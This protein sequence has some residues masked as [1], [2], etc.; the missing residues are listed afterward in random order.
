[1]DGPTHVFAHLGMIP[2]CKRLGGNS[3]LH[4]GTLAFLSLDGDHPSPN[5]SL[6]IRS[7]PVHLV[8]RWL[9]LY[10]LLLPSSDEL[11]AVLL[12]SAVPG[13]K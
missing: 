11:M 5:C 4:K 12:S 9:P 13:G 2:W 6:N 10:H 7:E 8:W 1:V 3:S